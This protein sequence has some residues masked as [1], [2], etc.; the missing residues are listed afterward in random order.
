MLEDKACRALPPTGGSLAVLSHLCKVSRNK[1]EQKG[2]GSARNPPKKEK[3]VG[4]AFLPSL[5]RPRSTGERLLGLSLKSLTS[6][7]DPSVTE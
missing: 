1:T 5:G 7:H 4:Q 6:S 3:K 2:T